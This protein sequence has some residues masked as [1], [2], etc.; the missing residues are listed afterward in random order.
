LTVERQPDEPPNRTGSILL[1]SLLTNA[2][3]RLTDMLRE[4]VDFN[5]ACPPPCVDEEEK[6]NG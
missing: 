6:G 2:T 4:F 3:G 1:V 5:Q